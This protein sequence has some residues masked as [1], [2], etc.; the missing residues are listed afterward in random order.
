MSLMM[1]KPVQGNNYP[2]KQQSYNLEKVTAGLR[3]RAGDTHTPCIYSSLTVELFMTPHFTAIS[4][5]NTK[6]AAYIFQGNYMFHT[7]I[8]SST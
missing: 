5:R 8:P 7:C 1:V 6:A 3:E 2:L 4:Y